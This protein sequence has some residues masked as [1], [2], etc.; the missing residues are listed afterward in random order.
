MKPAIASLLVELFTEPGQRVLDP[1]SGSG[2][3]PFEACLQGREGLAVD[4]SPLARCLSAAKVS[5]P[6]RDE[7]IRV[8]EE[9]EVF[10]NQRSDTDGCDI[11]DE[12]RDFYHPDTLREITRAKIFFETKERRAD[13]DSAHWLVKA[14]VLHLLHGNRPYALSRRSHGIIPIP[15]KGPTVY[16]SLLRELRAKLVRC[17]LDSIPAGFRQGAAFEAS[18]LELPFESRSVDAVITSPPFLGTTEFLRHNR[19]RLWFSGWSYARQAMEKTET[20]FLEHHRTLDIYAS[21]LAELR[22]VVAPSG[23]VV[24]HLGVVGKRDMAQQISAIADAS[25]FSTLA[26]IYEDAT[27]LESHGRTQ[28]GATAQHQFLFMRAALSSA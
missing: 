16:K 20:T 9:L 10:L 13:A 19:V 7:V 5:V 28:R 25:G 26:I 3:I 8:V 21:V 6:T 17:H 2:T 15:P 23:L 22:R 18:V 14:C 1:F 24:M 12:I 11:D 27:A 4:I